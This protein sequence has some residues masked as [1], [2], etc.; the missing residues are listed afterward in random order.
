MDSDLCIHIALYLY[1]NG[2]IQIL[3]SDGRFD[4]PT[5]DKPLHDSVWCTFPDR[6]T[7][8]C[9]ELTRSWGTQK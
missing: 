9:T 5:S 7:E 2:I 1:D 4:W 3:W 6:A 8:S